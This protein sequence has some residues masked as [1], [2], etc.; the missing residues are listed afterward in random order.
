MTIIIETGYRESCDAECVS[1]CKPYWV[2]IDRLC[3][4]WNE[5]QLS[6]LEAEEFCRKQG[7]HLASITSKATHDNISA[8]FE[9]KHP[10]HTSMWIGGTDQEEEGVWKWSDCSPWS[11]EAWMKNVAVNFAEEQD[12]LEFFRNEETWNDDDC[13]KKNYFLC[14]Q[15][16][17]PGWHMFF[18]IS[19][20][21]HNL[22]ASGSEAGLLAA[23][24]TSGVFLLLLILAFVFFF[25]LYK[26]K[27]GQTS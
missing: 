4:H 12:C 13:T 14:S 15:R 3:Y 6:W 17:C 23:G 11:F 18:L 20:P 21:T 25:L 27:Q 7:G 1:S 19:S 9:T 2:E 16:I 24:V 10:E 8:E 26:R 5:N 22:C